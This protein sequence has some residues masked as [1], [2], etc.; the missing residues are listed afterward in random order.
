MWTVKK[1]GERYHTFGSGNT[2][3]CIPE[4]KIDYMVEVD[5]ISQITT[6]GGKTHQV[7]MTMK[8]LVALLTE[9]KGV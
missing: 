8:E 5:G 3:I 7:R 9:S 6:V 4:S 2:K 1:V